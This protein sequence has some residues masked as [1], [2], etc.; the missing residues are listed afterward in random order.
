MKTVLIL[1][2]F[3][4]IGSNILRYL[5]H[6]YLHE[7]EVIVFSRHQR[8]VHGLEFK[9]IKRIYAGDFS[10][11]SDVRKIF[12]ENKI[13]IVIHTI[14][15]TV[16]AFSGNMIFDVESNLI[17]TVNLL[18]VMIEFG[19]KDIV[20]ISSGGAIYGRSE[21]RHSEDEDVFPISSHAIVKLSIE[22]YL[23]LFAQ[24]NS[25]N[26]LVLRLSNPYGLYHY[27]QKQGII[28]IAMRAALSGKDFYVWGDGKNRKDYIHIKDFCV[29]LFKLVEKQISNTI[30]NVGS[31]NLYSVNEILF[32]IKQ[33]VPLFQWKYK[34]AAVFDI[35]YVELNTTKLNKCIGKYEFIKLRDGLI[36]L[37][38]GISQGSL[39][40]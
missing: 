7:Y 12:Q 4:F 1:G 39:Y 19:T 28:N 38:N 35:P 31:G 20:Y 3:G 40:K 16:P 26:P 14:S 15:S 30:I 23:F 27:S 5:E 2:G 24:Q 36:D 9:K 8:H 17:P 10:N 32:E 18:N 34:E 29:I 25:I 37:Y 21:K 22:K 11:L 6:N 33:L 13:D